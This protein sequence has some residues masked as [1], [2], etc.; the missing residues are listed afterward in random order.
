VIY[1]QISETKLAEKSETSLLFKVTIK[2]IN[3]QSAD[4]TINMAGKKCCLLVPVTQ[5][6]CF[7]V[8]TGGKKRRKNYN[9][10][11]SH[12]GLCLFHIH[13]MISSCTLTLRVLF[14]RTMLFITTTS[15]STVTASPRIV[16]PSF[17]L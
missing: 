2:S 5:L 1:S 8:K 13:K 6:Y 9:K 14:G 17:A 11:W 7:T 4:I 16:I 3:E 10:T 12:C 15:S